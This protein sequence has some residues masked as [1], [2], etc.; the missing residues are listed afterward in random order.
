MM[1]VM[2]IERLL[3]FLQL[4]RTVRDRRQIHPAFDIISERMP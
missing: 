2:D 4:F 1:M 3:G